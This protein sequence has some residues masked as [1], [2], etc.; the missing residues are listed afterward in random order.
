MANRKKRLER[1]I[2][3]LE[4]R[5]NEHFKKI[6]EEKRK[7]NYNYSLIEYWEKEIKKL[8]LEEE[9]KKKLLKKVK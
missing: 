6:D 5:K 7:L 4:K 3:S 8:A 1:A 2:E 9:K